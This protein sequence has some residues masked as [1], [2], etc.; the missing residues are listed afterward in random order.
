MANYQDVL[1]SGDLTQ[2]LLEVLDSG[3]RG[4]RVG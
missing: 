1:V 3:G 2:K 4:E